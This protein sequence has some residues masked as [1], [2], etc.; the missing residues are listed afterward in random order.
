MI[1]IYIG[2]EKV[3]IFQ[4]YKYDYDIDFIT[5]FNTCKSEKATLTK[6]HKYLQKYSIN[7][8]Y[9]IYKEIERELK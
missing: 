9:I 8:D 1:K 5:E 6:I 7:F 2:K 3:K 4:E